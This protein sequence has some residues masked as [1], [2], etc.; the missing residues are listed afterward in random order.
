M[1]WLIVAVLAYL[2]FAIV[3]LI[4]KYLLTERIPD[5]ALY[6][7]YT[8]VLSVFIF[9]LAPFVDFSVPLFRNFILAFSVGV[10]FIVA[11][12]WFYRG[13]HLFETSRVVP[14]IGALAPIFSFFLVFVF[15]GENEFVSLSLISAFVALISGTFL[16]AYEKTRAFFKGFLYSVVAS[17]FFA[18]FFVLQKTA[19][20]AFQSFW[21]TLIW[22][23]VGSF[24]MAVV[25]FI[26][27]SKIRKEIF[28]ER[29][30]FRK[31]T[32]FIFF[33]NKACSGLGGLLQR[34]A[35]FLTPGFIE[36][37]IVQGLQ[38]VQYAFLF[39]LT[40]F[41]SRKFPQII[42]EKISLEIII[43]KSLAIILIAIGL[44]ILILY[45]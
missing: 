22:M 20:E 15:T 27:S 41:F 44:A 42:K 2:L 35:I 18:L 32:A 24:F 39:I 1:N 9:L 12:F 25:L 38:G 23:S 11:L 36:V 19:F 37:P 5:P 13:L 33:L 43:K 8:G 40:L 26:F 3:F 10:V 45:A 21:N 6:A 31:K 14:I 17:F 29:A 28:T 7:F 16:I 30:T 34:G 4:D